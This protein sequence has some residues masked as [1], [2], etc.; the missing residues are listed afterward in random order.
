MQR[1]IA[2]YPDQLQVRQNFYAKMQHGLS[3]SGSA[4]YLSYLGANSGANTTNNNFFPALAASE[5][6]RQKTERTI[7]ITRNA[8]PPE[9]LY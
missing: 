4:T 7:V 1:E 2:P 6:M 5:I 3:P 9:S 8:T